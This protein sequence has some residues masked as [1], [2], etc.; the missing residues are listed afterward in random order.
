MKKII[1][2][3]LAASWF[4]AVLVLAF[5]HGWYYINWGGIASFMDNVWFK[6]V[7]SIVYAMVV[8][9]F[10]GIGL[11]L[12]LSQRKQ[13]KQTKEGIDLSKGLVIR[14]DSWHYI[15]LNRLFNIFDM[16]LKSTI[17]GKNLCQYSWIFVFG[18]FG[19]TTLVL[20]WYFMLAI[21]IV[22][23]FIFNAVNIISYPLIILWMLFI[24][25]RV[26]TENVWKRRSFISDTPDD[27]MILG[28]KKYAYFEK[29]DWLKAL[30]LYNLS[31]RNILLQTLIM[32]A[33]WVNIGYLSD[34]AEEFV[35]LHQHSLIWIAATTVFVIVLRQFRGVKISP[36]HKLFLTLQ[37]FKEN[38]LCPG[39]VVVEPEKPEKV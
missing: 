15:T 2:R 24:S 18:G 32:S 26:P 38:N 13:I 11:Q 31:P 27:L 7:I 22:L 20:A 1:S 36:M 25:D 35:T 37:K 10:A 34:M 8:S 4:V 17:S 21:C 30:E 14:N 12:Y 33:I 3:V 39:I 9:V 28:L 19:V 23:T 6:S 29:Y 16:N 5:T